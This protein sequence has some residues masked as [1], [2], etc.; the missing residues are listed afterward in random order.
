[1]VSGITT[2]NAGRHYTAALFTSGAPQARPLANPMASCHFP[3]SCRVQA[4]CAIR[5]PYSL[6][7]VSQERYP[8]AQAWLTCEDVRD[9][10]LPTPGCPCISELRSFLPE[11]LM[12][13]AA[14][15][16]RQ[17]LE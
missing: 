16:I 5:V 9:C 4:A 6:T 12:L 3:T 1:M 14:A 13:E 8:N 11:L 15:A 17:V 10:P 2:P 7:R